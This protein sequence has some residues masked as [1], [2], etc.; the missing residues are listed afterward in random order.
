MRCICFLFCS[1]PSPH[2]SPTGSPLPPLLLLR[3]TALG[4]T[5]GITCRASRPLHFANGL[6]SRQGQPISPEIDSLSL[7]SS[8]SG[9]CQDSPHECCDGG[10]QRR[11]REE[12]KS[13]PASR[14]RLWKTCDASLP[15]RP[16]STSPTLSTCLHLLKFEELLIRC[17]LFQNTSLWDFFFCK[18]L[19]G[20]MKNSGAVTGSVTSG[21][22]LGF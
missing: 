4:V 13:R 11:G 14:G 7:L 10:A 5:A 17:L 22:K 18:V 6:I 9:F 12:K 21:L 19:C 8:P 2:P 3:H 1:L 15:H 16:P 20:V